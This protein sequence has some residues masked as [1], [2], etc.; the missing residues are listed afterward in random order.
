MLQQSVAAACQGSGSGGGESLALSGCAASAF[1]EWDIRVALIWPGCI[2]SAG[3]LSLTPCPEH[4]CFISRGRAVGHGHI[5]QH[6]PPVEYGMHLYMPER[7]C[8]HMD[9]C[10]RVPQHPQEDPAGAQAEGSS[11]KLQCPA[12]HGDV[13]ML[14]W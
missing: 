9:S 5:M 10:V 6:L 14:Q 4:P 13:W 12:E 8:L 11:P 1:L 2:L 3:R 7:G